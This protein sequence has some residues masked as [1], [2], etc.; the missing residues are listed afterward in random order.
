MTEGFCC[1][2]HLVAG[3]RPRPKESPNVNCCSLRGGRHNK[4]LL[5]YDSAFWWISGNSCLATNFG[6]VGAGMRVVSTDSAGSVS[7]SLI[8]R[9]NAHCHW[10]VGQSF[11]WTWCIR[12]CEAV[13]GPFRV[14]RDLIFFYSRTSEPRP[15]TNQ[16]LGFVFD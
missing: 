3:K 8:N 5:I 6:L 12:R 10:I 2:D 9:S 14:M 16:L 11:S 13:A 15:Y 7:D 4:I 1:D